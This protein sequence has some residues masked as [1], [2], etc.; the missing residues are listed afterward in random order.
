[1]KGSLG[2]WFCLQ[3]M[4]SEGPLWI[5]V[6]KLCKDVYKVLEQCHI[7]HMVRMC[8]IYFSNFAVFQVMI[9]KIFPFLLGHVFLFT[10]FSI[11]LRNPSFEAN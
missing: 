2:W 9:S 4:L 8:K 10:K 1:M 7:G 11:L 3:I 5:H 6:L